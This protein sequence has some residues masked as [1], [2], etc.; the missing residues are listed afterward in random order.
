MNMSVTRPLDL[1]VYNFTWKLKQIKRMVIGLDG[2][3]MEAPETG[4][5][6]EGEETT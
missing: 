5:I 2:V 6:K 1:H 3:S 4:A